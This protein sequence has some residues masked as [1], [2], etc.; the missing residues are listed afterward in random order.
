MTRINCGIPVES[1]HDKHLLA[2]AR[3]CKRIPNLIKKGKYSLKDQPKDFTLGK[4]HVKFFYDKLL[5]LKNRYE[6]L[7]KECQKRGF[8]VTY[9]GDSFLDLPPHLLNDYA[10]TRKDAEIVKQR[11]RERMPKERSQG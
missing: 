2:E 9:F 3:E 6:Q 11:I 10:P 7:F 1:L 8:K 5:Y 4:G